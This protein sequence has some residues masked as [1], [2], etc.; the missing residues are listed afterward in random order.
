MI[1]YLKKPNEQKNTP[2]ENKHVRLKISWPKSDDSNKQVELNEELLNHLFAK[3]GEIEAL[4][5]GK[6]STAILEYKRESDAIRCLNDEETLN[7]MHMISLKSLDGLKLTKESSNESTTTTT[8]TLFPSY[9]S[10][11]LNTSQHQQEPVASEFD[12]LED[13]ETRIFKKLKN[14]K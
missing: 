10:S 14:I 12:S 3:Y 4:V 13:L 6:K 5:M 2:A 7:R 1:F 9:Q 11:S 8:S